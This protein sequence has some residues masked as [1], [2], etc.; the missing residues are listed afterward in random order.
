[1]VTIALRY[2]L[3]SP[4][5]AA[6]SHA[7]AY[8]TTL[9]QCAWADENGIDM[10]VLSEHHGMEDGFLPAPLTLA[11]AIAGRTKRIPISVAAALIPLH[12][13]V[14]LAEQLAVLDLASGGRVSIVAGAGYAT[15]EFEMAGVDRKKRGA[16]LEEYLGVMKQA[17]T[18]EPFDYKGRTIRVTPKPM[19]K[20]HPPIFMGGSSEKAA[21][22]AARLNLWF[23]PSIADV[24]LMRMYKEECEAV[25]YAG[26]C[27]LPGGP[28][29]V[30]VTEDPE[31]VW[32]EIA[33]Y[34]WYDAD[35]YRSWQT[36]GN[37]SEVAT[38]AGNVEELK[39]EGIYRVVTPDECVALAE[40][41]GAFG[42][43][44][45]H[46]LMSGIPVELGWESLELFRSKV[47]PRIRP[48]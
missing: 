24:E 27:V 42:V 5:W 41:L 7:E 39:S 43:I 31:K 19:S 32:S 17:W 33:K 6:T 37:R 34:A 21:R 1:M 48:A 16:L 11:A 36:G 40:E 15:H 23:F 8:A 38:K 18:G 25:G 26:F 35:T 46:P 20:P 44:T 13:P 12:D 4:E 2:D 47:L 3:R 30:L 45:L 28:G 22:R 9:D 14:R 10:V 29:F